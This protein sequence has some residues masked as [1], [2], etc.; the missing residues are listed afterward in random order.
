MLLAAIGIDAANA[1]FPVAYDVVEKKY[2]G[3]WTWFLNLLK[4]DL[5]IDEPD[6]ITMISDRQKGFEKALSTVF[7]G[8]EVRFCVRHMHANFKKQFPGLLLKQMMWDAARAATK[9]EWKNR[10]NEINQENVKAYECFNNAILDARDKS[11]ITLLENIRYWMMSLFCN[12]RMSVSKCVHPVSKRIIDIIEKRMNVAKHCF[13][14]H[15]GGD[16]VGFIDDYYKRQEYEATYATPIEPMPSPDKWP[17]TGLNSIHPPTETILPG[18]PKKSRT[19]RQMNHHL[20][21]QQR[22]GELAKLITAA[23]AS[24]QAIHE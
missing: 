23:I 9:V 14:M 22:V 8:L 20:L 4:K 1:M 15:A 16:P 13:L 2:K 12:R 24:R 3:C 11:I 21:L 17:D 10:M 6:R 5:K 18:R 19:K 7:Q